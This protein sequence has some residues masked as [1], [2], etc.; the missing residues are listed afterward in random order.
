[1]TKDANITEVQLQILTELGDTFGCELFFPPFNGSL[2]PF[3]DIEGIKDDAIK[4][5]DFLVDI[6]KTGV[7]IRFARIKNKG[8]FLEILS[9]APYKDE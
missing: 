8:M 9:H 4:L 7:F 5:R 6:R 3:F 2:N 1:M